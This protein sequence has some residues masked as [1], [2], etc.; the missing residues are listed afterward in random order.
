M[1]YQKK[2]LKANLFQ[3]ERTEELECLIWNQSFRGFMKTNFL[4]TF[5]KQLEIIY[6]TLDGQILGTDQIQDLSKNSEIRINLEQVQHLRWFGQQENCKKIGRWSAR[7]KGQTLKDVGGYYSELGQKQGL[8]KELIQDYQSHA[9]AYELGEYLTGKKIGIWKSIFEEEEIGCGQYNQLSQK[10][11][12]WIELSDN[13]WEWDIYLRNKAENLMSAQIGGGNYDQKGSGLKIGKWIDICDQFYVDNQVTYIG[14]YQ[15]GIKIGRWNTNLNYDGKN[16]EIGGGSYDELGSGQKIGKWIELSEGFQEHNQV[17][18]YGEYKNGFKV[19]RWN[20]YFKFNGKN[21]EIGGGF[22]D[23]RENG[24]KIGKWIELS[25]GPSRSRYIQVIYSGEYKNS[26]KVG[27]WNAYYRDRGLSKKFKNI[28]GGQYDEKSGVKIGKWV[29]LSDN[30]GDGLGYSQIIYIGEY[31]DGKKFG[32]WDIFWGVDLS[33]LNTEQLGGGLY[34]E[35]GRKMG[36]WIDVNDWFYSWKQVTYRGEYKNGKKIIIII[37]IA[38]QHKYN[39]YQ[40]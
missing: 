7:W 38:I 8:W 23:W 29:E 4:I 22:Y 11:G 19:G 37:I 30:F 2:E 13:F 9:Q 35:Y 1:I 25:D 40:Q 20:T 24:Q 15:N 27:N 21:E 31:K 16:E 34:D 26:L 6:S 28:G 17:I 36:K 3:E 5:K 18:F 14:E 12:N 32:L 39:Y 33:N 10:I